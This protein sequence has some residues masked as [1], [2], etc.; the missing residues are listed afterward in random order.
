MTVKFQILSKTKWNLSRTNHILNQ[1]LGLTIANFVLSIRYVPEW[2]N[3]LFFIKANS[4]YLSVWL[5][6]RVRSILKTIYFFNFSL[7]FACFPNLWP[8]IDLN[9]KF[10]YNNIF[11]SKFQILSKTKW[12]LSRTN[13][14][15]NQI[16]G[17]TIANF[18]LSL[19][20]ITEWHNPLF[21]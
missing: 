12:N 18:V 3:P 20:Y 2:H 5:L 16:L 14:I 15:L 6:N 21:L 7:Y 1:I 17:L 19:R 8:K 13:H 4:L 9:I 11:D 10:R